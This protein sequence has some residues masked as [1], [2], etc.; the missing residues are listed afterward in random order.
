[1]YVQLNVCVIIYPLGIMMAVIRWCTYPSLSLQHPVLPPQFSAEGSNVGIL[2]SQHI[3][4]GTLSCLHAWGFSFNTSLTDLSTLTLVVRL[5]ILRSFSCSQCHVYYSNYHWKIILT[6]TPL[7]FSLPP[8][9]ENKYLQGNS[10]YIKF[11]WLT[12]H[13]EKW[14]SK[15]LSWWTKTLADKLSD[16]LAVLFLSPTKLLSGYIYLWVW[17]L[18]RKLHQNKQTRPLLPCPLTNLTIGYCCRLRGLL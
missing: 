18:T 15:I 5:T 9:P 6:L 3:S 11:A 2:Y 10:N 13:N 8:L 17:G 7:Q 16:A 1:M 14:M 4:T 12:T